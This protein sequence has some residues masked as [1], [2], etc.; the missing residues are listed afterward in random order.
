MLKITVPALESFNNET[1]EF[2]YG[3][4]AILQ[5]EH[6]LV[7]ISKWESKWH[8][9]F[10][11]KQ[12]KT[13]EEV[14]DYI[15]CMT[16]TQNVDPDIYYRL[17]AENIELINNYIDDPMTATVINEMPGGSKSREIITSELIYYWMIAYNIPVEFQKWHLN[18]LLTL[19][20]VCSVKNSPPKKMSARE[21]MA[22]NAKLNAERRKM[23]NSRG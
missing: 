7:S 21:V 5:L 4:E 6:S 18:R 9:A 23:L 15:R 20:R 8:K 17:S 11:G 1:Q 22:N 19:I 3:K 13:N 14:V 10:L 2:V 12:E 16:I